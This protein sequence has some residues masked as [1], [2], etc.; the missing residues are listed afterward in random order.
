[1][2]H[3]IKNANV[4]KTSVIMEEKVSKCKNFYVHVKVLY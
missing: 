1:M 2:L 3:L 4:P